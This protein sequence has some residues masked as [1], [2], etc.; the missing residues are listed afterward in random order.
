MSN[1]VYMTGTHTSHGED[2]L[3]LTNHSTMRCG[4]CGTCRRVGFERLGE[5]RIS[6]PARRRE[7]E[8]RF[9]QDAFRK[10]RWRMHII[11]GQMRPDCRLIPYTF[12]GWSTVYLELRILQP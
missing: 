7:D 10:L 9:Y 1:R 4:T 12:V 5:R 3:A 6:A 11:N 8:R 2:I